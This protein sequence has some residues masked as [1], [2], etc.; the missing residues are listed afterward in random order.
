MSIECEPL[1]AQEAFIEKID[2]IRNHLGQIKKLVDGAENQMNPENISWSD[3]SDLCHVEEKLNE[4][5][6]GET[7]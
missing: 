3:V 2:S 5:L 6:L 7:K 4:V 1:T